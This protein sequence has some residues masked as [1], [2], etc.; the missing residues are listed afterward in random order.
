MTEHPEQQR[1]V[2]KVQQRTIDGRQRIVN[3]AARRF[4]EEGYR[5][6]ST[7][8][9]IVDADSNKRFFYS[10]FSG[11][12]RDVARFIMK[13]TL[14]MD[15]LQDQRLKVQEIYDI[16]MILAYRVANEDSLLAALKLSFEHGS[17]EEYGTPWGDWV[18]FNLGQIADAQKKGE[19][20]P[21]IV[22]SEQARQLPGFWSGLVLTA[23]VLD[24]G[25]HDVEKHISRAYQN[26]MAVIA[27]PEV[28]PYMDF[29]VDRGQKLYL[30][31][32]E[33]QSLAD[34]SGS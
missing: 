25:L 17:N 2:R 6:A 18:Q 23:I 31:F 28:L 26:L 7:S 21:H 24:G 29:S 5:G 13:N 22:P 14:T 27:V 11:G 33:H 15:G 1:P 19:I 9:I 20:R 8:D 10:Q 16:G 12:K 34:D 4:I 30:E 32:L 3:A